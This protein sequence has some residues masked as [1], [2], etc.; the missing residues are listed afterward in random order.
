MIP[1]STFKAGLGF[2]LGLRIGDSGVPNEAE[3]SN[4]VELDASAAVGGAI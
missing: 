4:L 2:T 1:V 3:A